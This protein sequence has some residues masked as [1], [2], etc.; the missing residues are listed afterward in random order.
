MN[1]SPTEGEQGNVASQEPTTEVDQVQVTTA[2]SNQE[3][4]S[5]EA[6]SQDNAIQ[7]PQKVSDLDEDDG[8]DKYAESK[9][10]DPTTL[11]ENERRALKIAR[12]NQRD[13]RK[14]PEKKV[15]DVVDEL[16]KPVANESEDAAFKR[17]FRQ[18]K[19][20]QATSK[21]WGEEG[22]N[23]ELEPVMVEILNEKKEQYGKAYV[24]T[25][26][27][28]LDTLYGLAQLRS[29]TPGAVSVDQEAI[30]REERESIRKR[31]VAGVG[32]SHAVSQTNAGTPKIDR[33]WLENEYDPSNAEHIQL[34]D[35][36][37]AS[38]IL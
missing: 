38:G 22:R 26:V 20:E 31:Q 9:G 32:Q 28:D 19:A 27:S 7:T 10:F 21:F 8:L 3:T 14:G 6:V 35:A 17:E 4:I 33:D 13:F 30:R 11:T 24:E 23:R 12:D 18:F 15:T 25:L 36:A 29:G 37:V 1:N 2:E 34:V 5:Q 16:S